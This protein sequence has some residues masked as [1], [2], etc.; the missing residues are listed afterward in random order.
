MNI[1]DNYAQS[2]HLMVEHI[3]KVRGHMNQSNLSRCVNCGHRFELGKN[4]IESPVG[5]LCDPC[6]QMVRNPLDGTVI[7]TFFTRQQA[8]H[9][10]EELING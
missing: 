4:G 6:G 10:A 1:A 5:D 3:L 2:M 9:E 7:K 8:Q